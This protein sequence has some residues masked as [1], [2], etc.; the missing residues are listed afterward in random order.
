MP[1]RKKKRPRIVP[2]TPEMEMREIRRLRRALGVYRRAQRA[3]PKAVL[4]LLKKDPKAAVYGS[5]LAAR[6]AALRATRAKASAEEAR[7]KA[8]KRRPLIPRKIRRLH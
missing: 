5:Q 8:G 2:P 7:R 6:E 4:A 3:G 1:D